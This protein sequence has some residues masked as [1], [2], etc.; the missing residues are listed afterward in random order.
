MCKIWNLCILHRFDILHIFAQVWYFAHF[1]RL[2]VFSK[3]LFTKYIM[4]KFQPA[5]KKINNGR[6][7]KKNDGCLNE[8][9]VEYTTWI[10]PA[11]HPYF[12]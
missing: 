3:N 8:E 7:K 11:R 5:E 1:S 4:N 6:R 12:V 9:H 10:L 2:N